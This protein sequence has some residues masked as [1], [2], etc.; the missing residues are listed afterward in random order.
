M[1]KAKTVKVLIVGCGQ[2]GSRHLQAAAS[3]DCVDEIHVLDPYPQALELGQSRLKEISDLNLHIKFFW[4]TKLSAAA[5]SGDLCIMA[6]QAKGRVQ[7]IKDIV[8]KLKYKNFLTEKLVAQSVFEYEDLMKFSKKNR[9]SIWVN[10]KSRAY[11]VHQYIKKHLNPKEPIVFNAVGGNNGLANN[12]IHEADLFVFHDGT[13][14]IKSL[15]ARIDRKVHVTKRGGDVLDLTGTLNG[16]SKKGSQLTITF[17]PS[18][19]SPD[20]ITIF[21][22]TARFIIDHFKKFFYESYAKEDWQW[23]QVPVSENWAVSQMTRSFARDILLKGRCEL[24]TLE[25]CFPAHKFI[26]QQ[27]QPHFNRLLKKKNSLCPVT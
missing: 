15:E 2:L 23:R 24:P 5:A 21:S 1:A 3:L 13:D 26:L 10:C 25:E 20:L 4:S 6:T 8:E 14:E 12:G 19:T 11:G 22:P 7:V 27:L 16:Y 17:L 18:E 9:L